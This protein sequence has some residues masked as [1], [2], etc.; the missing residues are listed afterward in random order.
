MM[1]MCPTV[2]DLGQCTIAHTIARAHGL[3]CSETESYANRGSAARAF[4]RKFRLPYSVFIE[5]VIMMKELGWFPRTD[6]AGRPSIPL[7]LKVRAVDFR[8][9]YRSI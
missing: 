8:P 7:E 6:F 4:R 5:M 9:G 1:I 3:G 2:T